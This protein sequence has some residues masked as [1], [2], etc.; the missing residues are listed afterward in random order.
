MRFLTLK[1]QTEPGFR[2]NVVDLI[3]LVLLVSLSYIIFTVSE[4]RGL[5]ILPVYIGLTFFLF[6]N[7]F[8]IGNRL[9]PF[10]YIPFVIVFLTGFY[11]MDSFWPLVLIVCEPLKAGLIVFRIKKGDYR[12]AFYRQL[13]GI[14]KRG[15]R[16]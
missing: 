12:G 7:V 6:C 9:E 2:F 5:Y 3:F 1:K 13:G 15:A 8:R 10:W 11:T 4:E 14:G 16:P